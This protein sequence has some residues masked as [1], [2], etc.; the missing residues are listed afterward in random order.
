[1]KAEEMRGLNA[2]ELQARVGT[3]EEELFRARCD[4][5]IGQLT[6][7][8]VIPQIRKR[9]ARAKTIIKEIN[10]NGAEQG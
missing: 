5:V 3:W 4:K 10:S 7:T 6:D 1:M 8:S 2:D 9:I